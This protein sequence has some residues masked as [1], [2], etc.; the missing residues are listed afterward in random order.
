QIGPVHEALDNVDS[1]GMAHVEAKGV[2]AGIVV[3][4]IATTIGSMPRAAKGRGIVQRV[5]VR[6]RLD[7]HHCSAVFHQITSGH[8]SRSNPTK[9]QHF[10]SFQRPHALSL[11][12]SYM[13]APYTT[14]ASRSRARSPGCK[15]SS[16]V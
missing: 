13:P 9:I 1:L 2:F 16:C 11:S 4:I 8:G 15:P 14:P 3:G 6:L 12:R 10:Q 7:T 5:R